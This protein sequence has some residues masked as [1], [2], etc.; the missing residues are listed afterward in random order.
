MFA[1]D[2]GVPT[3]VDFVQCDLSQ[4]VVA[5][6]S[7]NAYIFDVEKAKPVTTLDYKPTVGKTNCAYVSVIVHAL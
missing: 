1:T 4:M 3:S 6:T 2:T 5:Y 7:G